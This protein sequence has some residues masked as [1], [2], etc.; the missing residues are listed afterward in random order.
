MQNPLKKLLTAFANRL[1]QAKNASEIIE[2][3]PIFI[4]DPIS[5]EIRELNK[6]A[7]QLKKNDI[8]EAIIC[9]RKANTLL[10]KTRGHTIATWLRL[11]LFLQQAGYFEEAMQEFDKLLTE[12]K[13]RN[14]KEFSHCTVNAIEAS[15]YADYAHIYDK[16]RL[17]CKRQKLKEEADKYAALSEK[18]WQSWE[19]FRKLADEE[20]HAKLYKDNKP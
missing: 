19:G 9:L 1:R 20:L 6:Q 4:T 13:A 17:A 18:H 8:N 14:T 11:P 10:S 5:A 16:M 3:T 7:T 2:I 12:T 15:I